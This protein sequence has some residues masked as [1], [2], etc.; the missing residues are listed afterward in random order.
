MFY[1]NAK[2]V[3]NAISKALRKKREELQKNSIAL[4]PTGGN[5]ADI[6][7]YINWYNGNGK[8]K[9]DDRK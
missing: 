6:I 9:R 2:Y 8:A 4:K 5:L 3:G 7:S 1:D